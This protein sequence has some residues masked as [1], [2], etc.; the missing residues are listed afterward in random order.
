VNII[1]DKIKDCTDAFSKRPGERVEHMH[2]QASRDKASIE[3]HVE[4]LDS[5]MVELREVVLLRNNND[6][7]PRAP[8]CAAASMSSEQNMTGQVTACSLSD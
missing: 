6:S 5:Q 2:S 3:T 7:V 1:K 4:K 8:S